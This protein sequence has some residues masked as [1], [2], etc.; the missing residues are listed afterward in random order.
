MDTKE[1]LTTQEEIILNVILSDTDVARFNVAI[2]SYNIQGLY[3]KRKNHLV[4]TYF[5]SNVLKYSVFMR[6]LFDKFQTSGQEFRGKEIRDKLHHLGCD[7]K[8]K[9]K[10]SRPHHGEVVEYNLLVAEQ[11]EVNEGILRL[12]KIYKSILKSKK[13]AA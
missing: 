1:T 10:Y 6:D 7:I 8:R 3:E 9:K 4:N 12:I 13:V 2:N 5:D 11:N